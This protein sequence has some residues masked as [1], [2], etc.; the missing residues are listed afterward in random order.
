MIQVCLTQSWLDPN[1]FQLIFDYVK[2]EMRALQVIIEVFVLWSICTRNTCI[3]SINAMDT[4][5]K[6]TKV[7]D[8]CI[9]GICARNNSV[10]GIESRAFVRLREISA[11]AGLKVGD[12]YLLSFLKLIFTSIKRVSCWGK[13]EDWGSKSIY[14]FNIR[15]IDLYLKSLLLT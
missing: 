8:A 14:T 3:D 1:V 5:I 2:L 9:R 7:R 10:G 6:Y 13:W 11:S 12:Y 15:Y 4:W